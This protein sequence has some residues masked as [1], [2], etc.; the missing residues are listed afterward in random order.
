[1][2]LSNMKTG[3]ITDQ[4][5]L[6]VTKHRDAWCKQVAA[7]LHSPYFTGGYIAPSPIQEKLNSLL[8]MLCGVVNLLTLLFLKFTSAHFWKIFN[9]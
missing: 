9:S 4:M 2:I 3:S 5:R 6:F 8:Y 7:S 1:M